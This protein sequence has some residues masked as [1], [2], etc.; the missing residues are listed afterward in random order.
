MQS[1]EPFSNNLLNQ[2]TQL[3]MTA[4]NVL[5][6]SKANF[7]EQVL[8][9]PGPVVV[10][11]WA[12]WCNPCKMMSPLLDELSGEYDSRVRIGKVNIED[13]QDLAN[14]YGV[15][16]IPTILFFKSGEVAEQKVGMCSKRDLKAIID[17][18]L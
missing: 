9:I 12:P 6:L 10:D 1:L 5:T 3:P 14:E 2:L 13:E 15:R 4:Q 18:L 16:A 17:R 8:S 11:F 7:S